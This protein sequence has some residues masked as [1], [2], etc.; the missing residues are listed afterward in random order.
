FFEMHDAEQAC[1]DRAG[2]DA[3]QHRDI[4]DEA[5]APF[6]QA[7]DDQQ[8]EQRDAEPLE[9]AIAR[10]GEGAGD[11]VD[12]FGQCR[13]AA[14]GPVDANPQANRSAEIRK[15]TSSGGSL[16]AR[17]MIRGTATAPAY[18]TSTCCRPS[19]NSRGAGS[20]WSTGW[21]SVVVVMDY[22]PSVG[23]PARSNLYKV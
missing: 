4:G 20:D 10:I 13:Q 17:P 2:D 22:P 7:E 23:P 14:A 21:I 8:H 19:A 1:E 18:M 5:R 9:L 15:A 16:K 3:E 11:A 6:D 12:H